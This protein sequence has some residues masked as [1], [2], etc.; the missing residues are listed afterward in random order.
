MN[1]LLSSLAFSIEIEARPSPSPIPQPPVV[2]VF[3]FPPTPLK[4]NP[5]VAKYIFE[6]MEAKEAVSQ[7]PEKNHQKELYQLL[8]RVTQTED[9]GKT[10]SATHRSFINSLV[11]CTH[12]IKKD[13]EKPEDTFSCDLKASS[14]LN[15]ETEKGVQFDEFVSSFIYLGMLKSGIKESNPRI[16]IQ[17]RTKIYKLDTQTQPQ[18]Y[19]YV[20]AQGFGGVLSE[21]WDY[22]YGYIRCVL[23]PPKKGPPKASLRR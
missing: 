3:P 21:A 22:G 14:E 2:P 12:E 15:T 13:K 10:S 18:C 23:P 19:R 1:L 17:N 20:H 6:G 7:I 5:E 9:P 16:D 11:K 8:Q 4:L